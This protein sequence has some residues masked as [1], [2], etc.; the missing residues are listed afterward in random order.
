M[1]SWVWCEN[2]L[3]AVLEAAITANIACFK[4]DKDCRGAMGAEKE[5]GDLNLN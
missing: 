1:A 2:D 4:N 3:V 5:D